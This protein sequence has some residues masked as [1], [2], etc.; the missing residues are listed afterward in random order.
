MGTRRV[1]QYREENYPGRADQPEVGTP[2]Q[3]RRP[4]RKG[5]SHALQAVPA[6][7]SP[8]AIR[9]IPQKYDL[10]HAYRSHAT[11]EDQNVS[12]HPRPPLART[13]EGRHA[14]HW[15]EKNY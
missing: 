10:R 13:Y 2:R 8:S 15:K 4:I 7:K 9:S 5:L 11:A 14:Y 6:D 1:Q 12:R 3:S